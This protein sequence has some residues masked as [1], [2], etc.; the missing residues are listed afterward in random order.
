MDNTTIDAEALSSFVTLIVSLYQSNRRVQENWQAQIY[1]NKQTN[2]LMECINIFYIGT[3]KDK[4]VNNLIHLLIDIFN[5]PIYD[6]SVILK[7]LHEENPSLHANNKA[8][9]H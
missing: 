2:V 3:C 7:Y 5:V 4:D 9:S 6:H 8:K 1:I